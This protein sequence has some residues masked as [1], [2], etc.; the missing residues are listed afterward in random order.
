MKPDTPPRSPGKKSAI[1]KKTNPEAPVTKAEAREAAGIH[2]HGD[3][4]IVGGAIA[5]A[6]GGAL[7][8][9]IAGPPGAIIG[10]IVGAAVGGGAGK[11]LEDA[12][13]DEAIEDEKLDDK[14]GLN[15][16][17]M[18]AA[19][20]NQPPARFGAFSSGSSGVTPPSEEQQPAEG[21]MQSPEK[22]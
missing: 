3:A 1:S 10:A 15:G 11:A 6:A 12:S 5:G 17:P 14:L 9:S 4:P 18:G 8:G 19:S 20:P 21:P 2:E 16:G 13:E 7:M 22:D